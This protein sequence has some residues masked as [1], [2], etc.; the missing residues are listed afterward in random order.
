[1]LGF[2]CAVIAATFLADRRCRVQGVGAG[3]QLT[4][5]TGR[6]Q[7]AQNLAFNHPQLPSTMS[8]ADAKADLEKR[9]AQAGFDFEHPDLETAWKAFREHLGVEVIGAK[10]YVLVDVGVCDFDSQPFRPA[11]KVDLC[12]QFGFFDEDEFQ[13]YEQL[14]LMLYFPATADLHGFTAGLFLDD[15][16]ERTPF[17]DEVERSTA[18]NKARSLRCTAA[19]L[20]YWQV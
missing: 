12:R 19:A 11:F 4:A 10:D 2:G 7:L 9:L 15:A 6:S 17:H 14:H 18:F 3:R 16:E 8:P 1:M 5:K 20:D 13:G